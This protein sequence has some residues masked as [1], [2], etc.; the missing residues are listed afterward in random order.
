MKVGEHIRVNG[1]VYE[2]FHVFDSKLCAVR[3][4]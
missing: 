4:A 2:I 1:K 3:E